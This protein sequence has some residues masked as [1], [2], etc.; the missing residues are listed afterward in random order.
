MFRLLIHNNYYYYHLEQ[1]QD[2]NI[3]QNANLVK[4]KH[5]Q[6]SFFNV[7]YKDFLIFNNLLT[8]RQYGY[9][10]T[11]LSLPIITIFLFY[12]FFLLFC[13]FKM[14][15]NEIRIGILYSNI[16]WSTRASG[17]LIIWFQT[18]FF[19]LSMLVNKILVFSI[20]YNSGYIHTL[21]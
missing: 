3:D 19:L 18:L 9:K 1:P 7:N 21:L 17:F 2:N 8:S 16:N 10:F 14:V 5:Q 6:K 15:Y 13:V 4:Y 20:E 11:I 12:Q